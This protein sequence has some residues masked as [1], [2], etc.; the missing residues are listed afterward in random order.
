MTETSQLEEMK[1][2]LFHE[3]SETERETLEERFF[4]DTDYFYELADLENNLVDRYSRRK[5]TGK[6]LTR[7]EQS[8]I[9]S[10]ERQAKIANARALQTLIAE[11]R[12]ASLPVSVP[13]VWERIAG[14]FTLKMSAL[15][16]ATGALAILLACTTGFLLY[17]NWQARQEFA[18]LQNE[19]QKELDEKND[20]QEQID[21]IWQERQVLAKQL[22][23]ERGEKDFIKA[24]DDKKQ[25]EIEQLKRR[26]E[27]LSQEK[28]NPSQ[29][30]SEINPP[31]P[32]LA[33]SILPTGRGANSV[34]PLVKL[35][36]TGGRQKARVTVPLSDEK[37]YASFEITNPKGETIDS[38]TITE[39][40]KSFVFYLPPENTDFEI[41]V[42]E[43][44]TRGG[45]ESLGTYQLKLKKQR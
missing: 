12:P 7:F 8:L 27:N 10:P 26:L 33:V 15:Q 38:G 1:R 14:F 24:E 11:E 34:N 6:D 22:E 13:T 4:E 3:M 42:S 40:A 29:N 30:P 17:Q 31:K 19:R 37:N 20:L 45:M 25:I 32:F 2:Y 21:R 28:N 18:K 39:G 5:L 16:Y 23:S 9:K 44:L 43:R 36:T 35:V 41:K